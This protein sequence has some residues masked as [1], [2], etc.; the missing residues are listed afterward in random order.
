M[1]G[2]ALSHRPYATMMVDAVA[3]RLTGSTVTQ[4]AVPVWAPEPET[5][6]PV[7]KSLKVSGGRNPNRCLFNS[8]R[9]CPGPGF[10]ARCRGPRAPAAQRTWVAPG[11]PPLTW[12]PRSW[13][14]PRCG[15]AAARPRA[16]CCGQAAAGFVLRASCGGRCHR[17]RASILNWRQVLAALHH[18][19]FQVL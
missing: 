10:T 8:P 7:M 19:Q 15:L 4:A 11:P 16:S 14:G 12:S 3:L 17:A 6:T 13:G 5:R 2:R 1:T 18:G 9:H